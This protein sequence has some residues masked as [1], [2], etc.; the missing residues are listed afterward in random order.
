MSLR[1]H[2]LVMSAPAGQF[3]EQSLEELRS[4]NLSNPI[5]LLL[6]GFLALLREPLV[7]FVGGDWRLPEVRMLLTTTCAA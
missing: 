4:V 1:W 6:T 7:D 3:V 5:V 2:L